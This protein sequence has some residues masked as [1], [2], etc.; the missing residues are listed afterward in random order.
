MSALRRILPAA[1]ASATGLVVLA[2]LFTADP[3]LDAIGAYLI[4]TAV[5][6]AA[7]ALLLGLLNVLR[8]QIG[9]IRDRRSGWA[10]SVVL[11]AVMLF[12]LAAG[13]LPLP[14]QPAGPSRPAV[15]WVFENVQAPIQASLSALLVF[16]IVSAAYR[17]LRVRTWESAVMLVVAVIVLAGQ[18]LAGLVPVLPE[19]RDWI[20]AVPVAAGARGILLGVALGTVLTSIRLLLGVEHPYGD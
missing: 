16:L 1:L 17:V 8:V 14:D 11:I 18:V 7:F 2:M 10:Y 12:V 19:L 6:V 4:D 20:L 3:R 9:Q 5:L 15:R 13:L